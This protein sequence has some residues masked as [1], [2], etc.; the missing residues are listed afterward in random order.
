MQ[1]V[2]LK[3][4]NCL[5]ISPPIF[6]SDKENIWRWV[7]SN[8]PPLGLASIASFVRARK[9]SVDLIDC[10]VY[11]PSVESFERFFRSFYVATY[12]SIQIIG[13]TS[14]TFNIKIALKIAAVCKKYYPAATI[15]AGGYHATAM[16]EDVL[17][18]HSVDIVCIG[19]GEHTFHEILKGRPLSEIQGIVYRDRCGQVVSTP[20]RPR[21]QDLDQIPMP[22]YDLLPILRYRPAKG[23]YKR[24]PA[25]NMITS[26]GCP[27][28]CT[29]CFKTLGPQLVFKSAEK[30]FEEIL[31]LVTHYGIKQIL[32][33]DDTFTVNQK[34]V[35]RLCDLILENSLDLSWTCFARVDSVDADMLQQMKKAGCHQ[36]MYG[37]ENID[38]TVLA[39][40][41]KPINTEQVMD[42]VAW[43]KKARIEC[44]LSFMVGNPGD[45]EAIIRKN[46]T[47]MN[48]VNPDLVIINIA[49]PFP[50]TDMFQW[51]KERNLIL[52]KNW[53]DYTL[54]KP[55]MRLENFSAG[56]IQYFYRLMYRSFYF[57]P[58]Y[59]LRQMFSIR[60]RAD[61][62][63][64]FS[65]FKALLSFRMFSFFS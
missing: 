61:M 36:V 6:Y 52:T 60:S 38:R 14:F 18:D 31:F 34:N 8:F 9:F 3:T 10:N 41:N 42:A 24:L 22:A 47:F 54:A 29:F 1:D 53:D 39:N 28:R 25:M 43:T 57:R 26:R 21:I 40:I 15:V 64:L 35:I 13:I 49:T 17:R 37:I 56:Q 32:F 30:I 51:A 20:L 62:I 4:L 5:L 65:G 19:E 16:P 55:I 44:R 2:S 59:I 11:A 48:T 27:G 63:R 46:I 12:S 7:N 33:Y 23:S 45:T 50:G 58:S